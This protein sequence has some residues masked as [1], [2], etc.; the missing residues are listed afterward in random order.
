MAIAVVNRPTGPPPVD[1]FP[2][3]LCWHG[4]G[5]FGKEPVMGKA[6]TAA[7]REYVA[8]SGPD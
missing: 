2:G 4:H 1:G 5:R 3:L 8:G 7:S 6:S